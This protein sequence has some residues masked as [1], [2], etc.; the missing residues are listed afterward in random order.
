MKTNHSFVKLFSLTIILVLIACS[1]K[2]DTTVKLD[3][4]LPLVPLTEKTTKLIGFNDDIPSPLS[5]IED[6]DGGL[7]WT[8]K[9][10]IYGDNFKKNLFERPYTSVEMNYQP[11][12]D[13]LRASIASDDD[14]YYFTLTMKGL[15]E[16]SNSLT[17]TYGIEIDRTKTGRGDLLIRV[18][19]VGEEWS[20][21][22][23]NV[24]VDKNKDVGGPTPI[25]ADENF[26]GDGYESE[27]PLDGVKVAYASL[28][29]GVPNAIQLAVSKTILEDATEF[30]WGGW[31]DK[32][33]N[34]PGKFDYNDYFLFTEAGSPIKADKT[35]PLAA[36]YSV[37]NTCRKP[38][39]F[40]PTESI[41]G[42]CLSEPEDEPEGCG[43][44]FDYFCN[45][46]SCEP[47]E[48]PFE[49]AGFPTLK[50]VDCAPAE[51]KSSEG[52]C[53]FQ[54]DASIGCE[55]TN[56][57]IQVQ[58]LGAGFGGTM[59]GFSCTTTADIITC[60][61]AKQEPG[62]QLELT[63]CGPVQPKEVS[64]C[65]NYPN[66][67]WNKNLGVCLPLGSYCCPIGQEWITDEGKCVDVVIGDGIATE[68]TCGDSYILVNGFCILKTSI[69]TCCTKIT[70]SAPC[71]YSSCVPGYILN[72]DTLCCE[73]ASP[74]ANVDC[75][76]CNLAGGCPPGCC[77]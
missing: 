34:D 75:R 77:P 71:C 10:V 45:N 11:D 1:E 62:T 64:N 44:N 23:I 29:P 2:R 13:I 32:G 15:D 56:N 72:P 9:R 50:P 73:K 76:T 70:F 4:A 47:N 67:F 25:L 52:E 41:P 49:P 57:I 22:N 58:A 30:L 46:F 5:I 54:Y 74:C 21:K 35:Y 14:F 36:L 59:E 69:G 61:G 68:S 37:D 40:S 24:F 55:G 51:V 33:V 63:M 7:A 60:E 43:A 18:H 65:R 31:A 27:M 38:F 28:L 53:D 66:H 6:P 3:L 42:M 17:G 12:I 19:A 48:V 26:E 8:E 16:A 20:D 39:G